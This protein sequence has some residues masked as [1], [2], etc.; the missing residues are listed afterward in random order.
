MP[1]QSQLDLLLAMFHSTGLFAGGPC[2]SIR[3]RPFSLAWT[4]NTTWSINVSRRVKKE[5]FQLNS[6]TDSPCTIPENISTIEGVDWYILQNFACVI[7]K[8]RFPASEQHLVLKGRQGD[9]ESLNIHTQAGRNTLF[10]FLS[11]LEV[12]DGEVVPVW[13]SDD[14][15]EVLKLGGQECSEGAL[16]SNGSG[17]LEAQEICPADSSHVT[18]LW[19]V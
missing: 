4:T 15:V 10:V 19:G 6:W 5:K 18:R 7:T 12:H 16:E 2:C 1:D 11:H 3:A 13:P 8:H 9:L 14:C 17:L